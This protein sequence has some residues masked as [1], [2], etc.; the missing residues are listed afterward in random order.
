M[1]TIVLIGAFG[2]ACMCGTPA[3]L[4]NVVDDFENGTNFGH[5]LGTNSANTDLRSTGGN[6]GWWLHALEGMGEPLFQF[7]PDPNNV[8]AGDYASRGVTGFRV[9]L[10]ADTGFDQQDPE[11]CGVT[12]RLYWT[13]GG[14]YLT[15]IEAYVAGPVRPPIGGGW[16]S[17]TYSIP[18][19]SPTIPA[20][21]TVWEGNGTPGTDADW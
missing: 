13:N 10:R 16:Y 7:L 17:Y 20:D 11:G 18:A 6:P 19:A 4:A 15:G 1:R 21:W 3:A 2:L 9:D 5:L 8:F 12:L 14:N